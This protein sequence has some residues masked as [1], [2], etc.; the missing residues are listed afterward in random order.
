MQ[1]RPRD[2]RHLG[3]GCWLL[4]PLLFQLQGGLQWRGAGMMGRGPSSPGAGSFSPLP[5][6]SIYPRKSDPSWGIRSILG[7]G[8]RLLRLETVPEIG[9]LK[10]RT[11]MGLRVGKLFFGCFFS[12][13]FPARVGSATIHN[14]L[15]NSFFLSWAGRGLFTSSSWQRESYK[16]ASSPPKPTYH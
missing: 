10:E 6:F 7:P 11:A 12:E 3:G 16:R 1:W 15:L 9:K 5:A 2:S 8:L 14:F 4:R 13:L